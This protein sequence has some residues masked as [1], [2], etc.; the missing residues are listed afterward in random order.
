[1]SEPGLGINDLGQDLRFTQQHHR[2]ISLVIAQIHSSTAIRGQHHH[3]TRLQGHLV[4]FSA[5]PHSQ[6]FSTVQRLL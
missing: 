6:H 5:W 1:M 4:L 3:V 2:V